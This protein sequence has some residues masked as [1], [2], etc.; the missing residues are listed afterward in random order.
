M[1]SRTVRPIR[2]R[3]QDKKNRKK[4][5]AGIRGY[6]A[7]ADCGIQ[8]QL[9]LAIR[10]KTYAPGG[11]RSGYES[12]QRAI[13]RRRQVLH[14]PKP[15][16]EY[17]PQRQAP[18]SEKMQRSGRRTSRPAKAP[19]RTGLT[20]VIARSR[21]RTAEKSSILIL[22]C[23]WLLCSLCVLVLLCST[24]QARMRRRQILGMI[25]TIFQSRR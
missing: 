21:N 25:C 6:T 11:I 23:C 17:R 10:Y 18:R 15:L 20:A 1:R 22:T 5:S 19:K 12:Y 9:N 24:A 2:Q 8:G 14:A 16:P 13:D 3:G 4:K 7:D